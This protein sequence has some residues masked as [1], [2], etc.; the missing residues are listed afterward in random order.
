[1]AVLPRP[2][3]LT[4]VSTLAM[5]WAGADHWST[6]GG[7]NKASEGEFGVMCSM[8][9]GFVRLPSLAVGHPING[10]G[11]VI[12]PGPSIFSFPSRIQSRVRETS[13]SVIILLRL[14][15]A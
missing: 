14:I 6:V 8:R 10:K 7:K 1:M 13:C 4:C 11:R 9:G 2:V 3:V 12:L 5:A 15:R